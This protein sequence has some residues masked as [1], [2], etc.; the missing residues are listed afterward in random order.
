MKRLAVITILIGIAAGGLALVYGYR[1]Y[2]QHTRLP[3]VLVVIE[4]AEGGSGFSRG[5]D[6]EADC[7]HDLQRWLGEAAYFTSIGREKDAPVAKCVKTRRPWTDSITLGK[8]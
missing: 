3:W 1:V 4:P 2:R 5:Y 6:S 7:K 8:F